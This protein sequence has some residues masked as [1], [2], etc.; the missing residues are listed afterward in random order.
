[1]CVI[2]GETTQTADRNTCS[3]AGHL[4]EP[5]LDITQ[6]LCSN[7]TIYMLDGEF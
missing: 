5:I 6:I 1:M 3:E 2:L 7:E 4:L